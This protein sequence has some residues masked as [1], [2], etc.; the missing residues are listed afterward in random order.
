MEIY[1]FENLVASASRNHASS[2]LFKNTFTK[3]YLRVHIVQILH[4]YIHFFLHLPLINGGFLS[5]KYLDNL[6]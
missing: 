1:A 4:T 2:K 5:I 3:M 6:N